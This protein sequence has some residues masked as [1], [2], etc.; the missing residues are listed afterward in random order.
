MSSQSRPPHNNAV[1]PHTDTFTAG[2]GG[3]GRGEGRGGECVRPPGSLL[4]SRVRNDDPADA[5]LEAPFQRKVHLLSA[6]EE[7]EKKKN[8][9]KVNTGMKCLE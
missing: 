2:K 9:G 7:G 4:K 1:D 3:R 5:S 6:T 8:G